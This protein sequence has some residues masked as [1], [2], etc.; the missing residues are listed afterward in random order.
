MIIVD[1]SVWID[2]LKGKDAIFERMVMLLENN[3]V[4][5]LEPI[6]AELLQGA[7]NKKESKLIKQYW[8][9]LPKMDEYGLWIEA[10]TLSAEKKY[11]AHGVGLI[12]TIII[13]TAQKT[14]SKI[15]SLD[16]KL[17]KALKASEIF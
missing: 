2:F 12:D 11:Y 5:A 15:W 3:Q 14:K 9:N 16:K 6:F 7:K 17:L 1:T 8:E 13:A 4:L 10:G